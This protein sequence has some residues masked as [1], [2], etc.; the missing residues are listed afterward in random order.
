MKIWKKLFKSPPFGVTNF[1]QVDLSDGAD[2]E[3]SMNQPSDHDESVIALREA[4]EC[5]P[6]DHEQ[7]RDEDHLLWSDGSGEHSGN[8]G[9]Q[10]LTDIDHTG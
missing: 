2:K 6:D 9:T 7:A 4:D 8:N 5:P 10:H 3:S 1:C